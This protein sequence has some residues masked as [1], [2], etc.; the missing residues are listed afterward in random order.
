MHISKV[1]V[2][3][4]TAYTLGDIVLAEHIYLITHIHMGYLYMY[5]TYLVWSMLPQ[6]LI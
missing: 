4:K 6:L 2:G 5:I 3:A 1:E